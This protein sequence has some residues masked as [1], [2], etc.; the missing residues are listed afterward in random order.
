MCHALVSINQEGPDRYWLTSCS[1]PRACSCQ[2]QQGRSSQMLTYTLLKTQSIL[3]STTTRKG[4]L[5]ADLHAVQNS[6][7]AL[8]SNNQEGPAGCWLTN[9]SKPRACS[10]QQQPGRASRML[11]YRLFKTQSMLLST[12]SRKGQPEADLLSVQ[13]PEHGLVSNKQKGPAKCW[14]TI[15]SKPRAG[16]CQQHPGRASQMLTYYLFKTQSMLLSAT[17]RK[18]QPNSDLHSVYNPEHAL[19]RNKQEGPARFWRASQVLTY[20]LFKTQSMLLSETSRKGQPGSD[21]PP[22]QNQEHALVS[23]KEKGAARCWLTTCSK[24]RACSCQQQWE[25][26]SQM[27]TY[28][29]FKT[30]SMLLSATT[31]KG[32]PDA[33]LHPVQNPEHALV[34]NNQEGPA[35]CWLTSCSKPRACT[36]Q[37]QE[38]RASQMLTYNLFTT[39]SMHLSATGGKGQPNADLHPVQNPEHAL[40][41]N[42]QAGPAKCWLTS[43][44]KPRACSCQQQPGRTSQMLT[45]SLFKTQSMLL[46]ATTRKDQTHADLHSVQNPVHAHVSNNQEGPDRC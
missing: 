26:G 10:C 29:L 2:Q 42:N 43:C 18:G 35:R 8:V 37:Q 15:C 11:T 31:R 27:L 4:Q 13:N 17:P 36:C 6:E 30:Q 1:K 21:L 32:Q 14:L 9:C 25:R 45:Y 23:N 38:G 19:I 16:S 5:D 7:Q 22:V 44:S 12:T 40:V 41:S 3:L 33:D 28:N 46:S 39:P 24:S 34:S 20:H